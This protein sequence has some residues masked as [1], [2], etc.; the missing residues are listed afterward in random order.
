MQD[1]LKSVLDK[2]RKAQQQLHA[3]QGNEHDWNLL[4]TCISLLEHIGDF[5]LKLSDLE[6]KIVD[7]VQQKKKEIDDGDDSI[8]HICSNYKISGKRELNDFQKL[9]DNSQVLSSFDQRGGIFASIFDSIK[10]ICEYVHDTTLAAIFAPIDSQL[11]TAQLVSDENMELSGSDL[12]D[13]SF[14]PQEFIT[15]IGQVSTEFLSK[16]RR[17]LFSQ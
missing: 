8:V 17:S 15:V 7:S 6:K 5:R 14:A 1:F 4:Q 10:P 16:Q 12:P 13:Y 9:V 3:S 11:R 2:F